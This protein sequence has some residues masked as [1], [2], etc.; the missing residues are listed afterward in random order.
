MILNT[1]PLFQQFTLLPLKEQ[2]KL[3][4]QINQFLVEYF[5]QI[6]SEQVERETWQTFSKQ[7]LGE[8]YSEDEPDYSLADTI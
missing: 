3:S 5:D 6:V 4:A 2:M 1:A 7:H 8:A